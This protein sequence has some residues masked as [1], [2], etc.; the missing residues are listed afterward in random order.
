MNFSNVMQLFL[1]VWRPGVQVD[2]V[3]EEILKILEFPSRKVSRI[4]YPKKKKGN[5]KRKL[6]EQLN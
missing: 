6:A 3:K 1:L 5:I 4:K 2:E